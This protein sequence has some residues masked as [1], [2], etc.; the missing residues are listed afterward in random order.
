MVC[1]A[2]CPQVCR[3]STSWLVIG[4]TVC[5]HSTTA[6]GSG[7]RILYLASYIIWIPIIPPFFSDKPLISVSCTLYIQNCAYTTIVHVFCF[8]YSGTSHNRLSEIR[9]VSIQWDNNVPLIDFAIE[10]IYFQLPRYGQSPI[11][12]QQT[13]SVP[14]KDKTAYKITS[15]S[16]Q[17]SKPRVK[18]ACE[19][20]I[21]ISTDS[22]LCSNT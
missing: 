19:I 8:V 10:I 11:S 15:K 17:R 5:T 18:N 12:R 6:A 1:T 16:G 20:Y 9:T 14:P 3:V 13:E 7:P 22:N 21:N 4:L 2:T